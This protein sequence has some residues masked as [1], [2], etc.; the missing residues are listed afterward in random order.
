[1]ARPRGEDSQSVLV[2]VRHRRLVKHDRMITDENEKPVSKVPPL[3]L[4]PFEKGIIGG[5]STNDM[6]MIKGLID[7]G[8]YVQYIHLE[9]FSQQM[10]MFNI[11]MTWACLSAGER[12]NESSGRTSVRR[13][14]A[15]DDDNRT[16]E[17]TGR[18]H[19]I[20]P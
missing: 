20:S 12:L 11:A 6:L 8:L 3:I 5:L 7:P 1:M 13:R 10:I 19:E 9:L 2:S 18:I 17:G 16:R 15:F 4:T 14:D